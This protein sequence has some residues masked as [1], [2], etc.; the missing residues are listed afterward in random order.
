MPV[1]GG[2]FAF[3]WFVMMIGIVVGWIVFLVAMWRMA[4]A[5]EQIAKTLGIALLDKRPEPLP[6]APHSSEPV[7]CMKCQGTIPAGQTKCPQCG[8]SYEQA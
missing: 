2:F 4:K 8:W 3:V 1:A 6:S 7:E 5:Q